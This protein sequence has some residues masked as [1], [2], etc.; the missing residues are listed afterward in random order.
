MLTLLPANKQ[1]GK[2][3]L[4]KLFHRSLKLPPRLAKRTLR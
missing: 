4:K 2:P 1:P 3:N